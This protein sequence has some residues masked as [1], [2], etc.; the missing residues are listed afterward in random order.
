MDEPGYV[1]DAAIHVRYRGE[2]DCSAA[3]E[4]GA[5]PKDCNWPKQN[6][7]FEVPE[8]DKQTF[9]ATSIAAGIDEAPPLALAKP[10][11]VSVK[12]FHVPFDL[13]L[14]A[15]GLMRRRMRLA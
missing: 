9:A 13:L 1:P 15:D 3:T 4:M 7:R 8:C 14:H 11:A 2:E 10:F 12:S 5:K 6:G